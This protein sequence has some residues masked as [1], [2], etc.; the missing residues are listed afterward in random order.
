MTET[1]STIHSGGCLCGQVRFQAR[2]LGP[3]LSFCHCRQCL[4]THGNFA[5]Y[6]RLSPDN[7]LFERQEGLSWYAS[8]AQA[9]RG[10]CRNCGASL[11][12][13]PT[14]GGHISVSAGCLD[15]PTGLTPETHIF[16]ASKGDY[17]RLDDGLP[18][19]LEYADGPRCDPQ[20]LP[21]DTGRTGR[22]GRSGR[23]E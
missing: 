22:T 4:K 21:L 2:N 7:L 8:S 23:G 9:K 13:A 5:A 1:K 20:G 6:A 15:Q 19:Y 18:C 10:F 3:A 16:V 17:Y 11:F 12:W 14:Q